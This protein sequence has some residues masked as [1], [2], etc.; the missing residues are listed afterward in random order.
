[1]NPIKGTIKVFLLVEEEFVRKQALLLHSSSKVGNSGT[2][3]SDLSL[4]F[5]LSN[6][7]RAVPF[8]RGGGRMNSLRPP[9]LCGELRVKLLKLNRYNR[10][11][12]QYGGSIDNRA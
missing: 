7:F 9:C 6:S 12:D 2:Y 3:E 1:V 4:S 8:C 5:N 10:R 11:S